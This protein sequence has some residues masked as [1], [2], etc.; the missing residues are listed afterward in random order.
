MQKICIPVMNYEAI[1]KI[2]CLPIA[3]AQLTTF[4]AVPKASV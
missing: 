1:S 4:I 2:A 3:S